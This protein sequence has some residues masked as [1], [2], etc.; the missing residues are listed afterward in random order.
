MEPKTCACGAEFHPTGWKQV[1]CDA[2]RFPPRTTRR[3]SGAPNPIQWR[4]VYGFEGCYEIN[5]NGTICALINRKEALVPTRTKQGFKVHLGVDYKHRQFLFVHRLL[6]MTFNPIEGMERYVA[7]PKNGNR[8][9]IRLENWR[10]HKAR[11]GAAILTED[12][13]LSIR[14]LV[15]NNPDIVYAQVAQEF[16]V[17]KGAIEDIM[18][19]DNWRHVS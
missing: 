12:D 16:H 17:S 7:R 15:W 4:D 9:D 5:T 13:V 19:G 2:C 18:S 8:F 11:A 6:L 3:P 10:W 1:K 14:A